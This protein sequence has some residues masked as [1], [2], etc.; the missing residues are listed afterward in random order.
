[1][2]SLDAG[3]SADALRTDAVAA[4]TMRPLS[5]TYRVQLRCGMAFDGLIP[6]LPYLAQLGVSHLYLSPIFTATAGSTHGYDVTDPS[7]IDPALGGMEG[8]SRLAA[9]AAAEGLGIILDI[10]PNHTAFSLENP[11]LRDLLRH[12]QSSA[13]ARHFD[14]DWSRRLALPFLPD[15]F[16]DMLDRGAFSLAEEDGQPVFRADLGGGAS[17]SVPLAPGGLPS[18]P[19]PDALRALHDTQV[20]Q[21]RHWQTERDS[22]THRRF[23]NVTSLIGMRVEEEDV[24]HDTHELILRLV[25]EGLVQG[26][27]I[28]HIDGL[29]D[30]VAYLHRLRQAVGPD[31]PVW[32]E[33]ILTGS[34]PLPVCWPVQGTTGYEAARQILRLLTPA[35]GLARLDGTWRDATGFQGDFAATV[36]EAKEEVVV[37]ELAAELHQMIAL[38]Q[39]YAATRRAAP[40]PESLREAVLALLRTFPRYRAYK[41]DDSSGV[42]GDRRLLDQVIAEAA[43]TPREPATV[44]LLGEA[45]CDPDTP[46]A[47]DFA[48][49]FHQVTGA[50]VAKSQEDTA[51]FRYN[52]CLATNEVGAEPDHATLTPEAMSDWLADRQARWPH[53]LTLTS[54]HD[55][56]RSEDARTRL[57][58]AAQAPQDFAALWAETEPHFPD[59]MRRND[60][61]YLLQSALAIWEDGRDDL[62][63]RL[64]D[65]MIKALREGKVITTWQHPDEEAEAVVLEAARALVARWQADL[66][67]P[68][69]RL[70]A[71]AGPLSLIQLA[72]KMVMPGV[73]D[74]YQG[75]ELPSYALTDPDNRQLVDFAALADAPSA[76]GLA[77]QKARLTRRLVQLRAEHPDFF[78]TAEVRL[79]AQDGGLLEL[80]R[81]DGARHLTLR[82]H[83]EGG[84]PGPVLPGHDLLPGGADWPLRMSC[85][86]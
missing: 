46:E 75:T 11:W 59:A 73:P 80:S 56:K 79:S 25:S 7:Q 18:D 47:Q 41:V 23:F 19:G 85:D 20:W 83:P 74:I 26:L 48:R 84:G 3:L 82:F 14:I 16:E 61:W 28:D 17:L 43:R 10:V 50:L 6:H 53:A 62:A 4:G 57:L 8:F 54:S 72:L 71:R 12:G 31:V 60:G 66:P 9:S 69:A 58:A 37:N 49:R 35:E 65:H 78:D 64:A 70:I 44:H 39:A 55:T 51:F 63:D 29:A 86:I 67:D 42:A 21:L 52:R 40:G 38:A 36:A 5:T 34:E 15:P 33:K 2:T 1:M 30:P 13:Y 32:V 45:L 81:Q 77:G 24:F 27:R 22:V 68:A 76:P